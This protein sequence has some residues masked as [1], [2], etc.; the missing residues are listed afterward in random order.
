METITNTSIEA[1]RARFDQYDNTVYA[2]IHGATLEMWS[3][4]VATALKL[5]STDLDG[6]RHTVDISLYGI[7]LA[8][9]IKAAAD[10]I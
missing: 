7:T 2:H 9:I 6:Q 5:V 4:G 3:G 10:Q 1:Y 8:D